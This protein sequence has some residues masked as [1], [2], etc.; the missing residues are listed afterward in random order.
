MG[1]W[2][3]VSEPGYIGEVGW[4]LAGLLSPQRRRERCASEHP[5]ARSDTGVASSNVLLAVDKHIYTT[6]REH[7]I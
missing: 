2:R 5:R 3:T 7:R 1:L 6:V 4:S